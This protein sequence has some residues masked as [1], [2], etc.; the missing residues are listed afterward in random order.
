VSLEPMMTRFVAACQHLSLATSIPFAPP[1]SLLEPRPGT[2]SSSA[3]SL[4]WKLLDENPTTNPRRE[5]R[6]GVE[7]GDGLATS[8]GAAANCC[9]HQ[10]SAKREGRHGTVPA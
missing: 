5:G 10:A 3:D 4:A 6:A 8:R 7:D 1:R 2:S 9:F